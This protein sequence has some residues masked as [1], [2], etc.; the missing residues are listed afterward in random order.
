MFLRESWYVVA[1]SR[2]LDYK[3]LAITVL[4]EELVVFRDPAGQVAV[5][6]DR[7]AHRHLP[8]SL[9]CLDAGGIRCGYHGLVFDAGGKCVEVPSQA[10]IP[11]KARVRAY[12]AID[13]FGWVWVWMGD[14]QSADPAA[15]PD[16]S[17]LQSAG[18]RAV[19]GKNHVLADYR[20]VT[21]NLMDLSHVGF[22]HQSTIGNPEFSG[23][24]DLKTERVEH[25]V[26]VMRFVEDIPP[27]PTYVRS[28]VLPQGRNIDR[29]QS[30]EFI[31]PCFVE[32]HV[33]GK[34]V[35]TGAR[36]G[37]YDGGLNLWVLNAMTP[38]TETTTHYFWAS[39][40]CH[41]LDSEEADA[42]FYANVSEAFAED[43]AVLEAQ[44]RVLDK[45]GDSWE[46]ALQADAGSIQARRV[47][48]ALVDAESAS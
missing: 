19:G 1:W 48:A 22:V 2:D 43:K 24:S 20:L 38:E 26:K 33:G 12:P 16:F 11:P 21:D 10:N 36:D 14:P 46:A 13:K 32:I 27:P 41:A 28:G 39:V 6:E 9:G 7:C 23:K 15:I 30:I 47:L 17:R 4:N 31:A 5:L 40:R 34:E 8:L 37:D 35:G 45:H 42:F 18:F 3:P 44:Q 29:W 25:G